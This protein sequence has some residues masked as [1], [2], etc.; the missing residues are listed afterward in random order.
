MVKVWR[1]DADNTYQY[2]L[3][4]VERELLQL[5]PHVQQKD[6]RLRMYYFDDLAGKVIIDST[7]DLQNMLESFTEEW[8][9]ECARKSFLVLHV[10]DCIDPAK[11]LKR[12]HADGQG[13]QPPK[14]VATLN[15]G[16]TRSSSV[17]ACMHDLY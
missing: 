5:F 2:T 1:Y 3:D 6:L 4:S 11:H 7:A 10:E 13:K 16:M 14:K 9:S 8:R 12:A 15:V 17:T